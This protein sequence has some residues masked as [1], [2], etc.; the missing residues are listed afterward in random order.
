MVNQ[1]LKLGLF[2]AGSLGSNQDC[3][4]VAILRNDIDVLAINE[5]WLRAGEEAR[6]PVLPGYTLRHI[7]R[8]REIR[9]RG[10]GVG[11]YIKRNINA[12]IWAHPVDPR[13]KAV[14]Q[15]WITLTLNG[16][17]LLI[18]TAYRP[19]WLDVDLFFDAI[20]D[21]ITSCNKFDKLI[22]MGDF[23]INF[24]NILEYRR[25]KLNIFL[26]SFNLS[27]VI[28]SPTH[29]TATSQT[30]IDIVCT[31]LNAKKILLEHIGSLYGHCLIVCDFNIRRD[32][33]LP[34]TIIYRSLNNICSEEFKNNLKAINW[35]EMSSFASVNV[36]V[37]ALNKSITDLFDIH[38][39][40]KLTV[41][42]DRSP[43]WLTDTIKLMMKLR[44]KAASD[45]QKTKLFSKK[46][47]YKSLKS[48]VNKAI[49]AEKSAYFKQNIN[50]K[51]KDPK[52]L[53][54]NLKSIILSKTCIDL[55][56]ALNDPDEINRHFLNIPS[57]SDISLSLLNF[58]N[59]NKFNDAVFRIKH[60]ELNTLQ[61]IIRS[62]K[63]NAEGCDEMSLNMFL[64]TLPDS[65]NLILTILNMSIETSTFPDAWKLAIVRPLPKNSNPTEL[66]DLRPIS[67]LPCISKIL[68]KAVCMQLTEFLESNNILPELQSGFR[69]KRGTVTALLDVVDNII[70]AQDEGLCTVLVLLDFS[71][72]F[73][74]INTQ[75]LISKMNYYGFDQ[76]AL[77]WFDSYLNN[78]YQYVKTNR[79]D[80]S[81]LT[82]SQLPVKRGVPQ[83]SILGPILFILYSADIVA[84][85]KHCKVH[86]YADDTQ[87]YISCKPSEIDLAV[88][89]LNEDLASLCVWSKNN[90][91]LLNPTKTKFLLFGSKHQLNNLNLSVPV[92]L[93]DKPVERVYEARNLGLYVDQDLRFE[94][95]V[96]T[97][98]QSCFY[99]LK[100]LYKIRPYISETLRIQ[101]VESLI[102]SRLNYADV[103]IGPRILS[104]TKRLIQRVQNACA[105]FCFSIPLRSHVTPFLNKYS[106]LKMSHRRKFHLA[107]LLFG[108]IKY[109]TPSYLYNKLTWSSTRR[110]GF[111]QCAIQLSVQRHT[112]AAFRGSFRYAA[113]KCWNNIPP[114]LRNLRSIYVFKAKLRKFLVDGQIEQSEHKY[115][116]SII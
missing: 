108:V 20:S 71:R 22:L 44:D 83:G 60:V 88:T 25:E 114:P 14:E 41:I 55:P 49:Y 107:C 68:E 97:S 2:N 76:K 73:D 79:N 43:P 19:P 75:L 21:S 67:I 92:C 23:N 50:N 52:S 101:L 77:Q 54:K 12:H 99:K 89:K 59:C 4:V 46:E 33:P 15:M 40:Q 51:I 36:M 7:P 34:R 86:I 37:N 78:R 1:H 90:S 104:K 57:T 9:S 17:R 96:T 65:V 109:K 24:A 85:V 74:S 11:F 95:H 63:S 93:M 72:A 29:F 27:Q 39:P 61:K 62:L 112:T 30:I 48:L 45:Y 98:V 26:T 84:Q 102:L 66:K 13:N 18:G 6:A 82:S 58:Y 110:T 106:I 81:Y 38:A 28:S 8:P 105:R 100:V 115:D 64:M 91:L 111:R 69:K 80:G 42:K 70:C 103:V 16:V 113:T 31:D 10:G 56:L 47:Y 116:T 32:K 3:F 53:W 35:D 94:R 5:T 87:I